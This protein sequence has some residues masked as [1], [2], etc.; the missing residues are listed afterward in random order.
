M[1]VVCVL[2]WFLGAVMAGMDANLDFK[3]DRK[4][5]GGIW[6]VICIACVV[7]GSVLSL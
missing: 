5:M 4:F 2:I 3:N 6:V 7:I 1:K